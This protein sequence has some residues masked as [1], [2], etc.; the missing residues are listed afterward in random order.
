[1]LNDRLMMAAPRV[2]IL[3]APGT[4]CDRET[5]WSFERAGGHTERV[6]LARLLEDPSCLS[7]FQVLC[8]PG[9]FSYGDDLG[10]G[11][12]FGSQL[13]HHLRGVLTEFLGGDRLALGICNGFQVLMRSGLLPDGVE[14]PVWAGDRPPVATLTWNRNGHYTARWVRLQVAST[15]NVFLRGMSDLELPVAHAEGR[16]AVRDPA[17]LPQWQSRG[18]SALKYAPQG[19]AAGPP[20]SADYNPNGSEGDIAALGDP[21]GRILGLMPHPE[22][23]IDA[24]QHPRWTRLRL[25]GEGAGLQIFR[26]AVEYFR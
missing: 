10:A 7:R 23:F 14:S 20:G 16:I 1:L 13:R 2:C 6:H 4:N 17:I 12:V 8:I 5:A 22:R 15:T 25:R 21:T 11:V 9:G 3:R 24:T 26:N 18:Q 19:C